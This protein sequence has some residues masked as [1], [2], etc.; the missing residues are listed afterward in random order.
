MF[1]AKNMSSLHAAIYEKTND[2]PF[3]DYLKNMVKKIKM[4]NKC[5]IVTRDFN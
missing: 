3:L 2:L 4:E 5:I 1:V